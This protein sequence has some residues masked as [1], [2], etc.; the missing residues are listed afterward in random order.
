LNPSIVELFERRTEGLRW[1]A[2]SNVDAIAI[3]NEVEL[4]RVDLSSA[5]VRELD[6]GDVLTL[7]LANSASHIA[8]PIAAL[9]LAGTRIATGRV[10]ANTF[11]VESIE[12]PFMDQSATTRPLTADAASQTLEELTLTCRVVLPGGDVRVGDIAQWGAGTALSLP[13]SIDSDRIVLLVGQQTIARGRLVAIGDQLG[14]EI[15]ETFL[16]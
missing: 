12:R 10:T 2:Q 7:D 11:L 8:A 9:S 13:F 5:E 3:S 14:F 6:L 1:S 15:V 16:R 4:A